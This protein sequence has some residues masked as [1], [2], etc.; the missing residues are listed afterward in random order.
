MVARQ[1][2]HVC[3]RQTRVQCL[4]LGHVCGLRAKKRGT[5]SENLPLGKTV[6]QPATLAGKRLAAPATGF[7]PVRK[8]SASDWARRW[9]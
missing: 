1:G 7:Q 6:V 3:L 4:L 9:A 8:A 2:W 5:G